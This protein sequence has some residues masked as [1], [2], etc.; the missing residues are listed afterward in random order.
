MKK[1]IVILLALGLAF[2]I[3]TAAAT[4]AAAAPTSVAALQ[5]VDVTALSNLAAGNGTNNFYSSKNCWAGSKANVQTTNWD[6]SAG[7]QTY[8]VWVYRASGF[9]GKVSM[10]FDQSTKWS[11]YGSTE[12]YINVPDHK[13]HTIGV[14]AG[15]YGCSYSQ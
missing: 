3:G 1:I 4:S 13:A 15:G 9:T 5:A 6:T 11:G 14:G 8:H 10:A 2:G 7:W 12:F